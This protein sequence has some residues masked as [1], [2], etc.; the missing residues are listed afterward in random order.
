MRTT[1]IIG[2]F[3][4]DE[5]A[6]IITHIPGEDIAKSAANILKKIRSHVFKI[7]HQEIHVS[8]S[9]G[10]TFIPDHGKDIKQLIKNADLAL[11]HSKLNNR[12][13]YMIYMPDR[14]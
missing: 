11:Y 6:V 10:F 14:N 8:S 7:N 1:D 4:G 9:V 12:N 2:R 3:G 13:S 5:F